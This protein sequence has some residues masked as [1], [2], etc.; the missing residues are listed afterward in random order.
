MH[1]LPTEDTSR[2]PCPLLHVCPNA[3][4]LGTARVGSH[5]QK[6]RRA[7]ALAS[8]PSRSHF[9]TGQIL[10]KPFVS[11]IRIIFTNTWPNKQTPRDTVH[12][13]THNQISK[14][15]LPTDGHCLYIVCLPSSNTRGGY[16]DTQLSTEHCVEKV[17]RTCVQF[18]FPLLGDEREDGNFE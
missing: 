18:I 1:K 8:S 6:R 4:Q 12:V 16:T 14:A 3:L 7:S 15:S 9:K 11:C 17:S 10:R 5:D 2:W 13:H